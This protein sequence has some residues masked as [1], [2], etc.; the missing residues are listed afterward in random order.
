MNK[1]ERSP[2]GIIYIATNS[3]NGK[4]YVGKTKKTPEERWQV[5][6]DKA[7]M[8]ENI[9]ESNPH[10]K[11]RGT[12]LNNAI[13]KYGNDAFIDDFSF[14][15]NGELGVWN[16]IRSFLHLRSFSVEKTSQEDVVK[17]SVHR[18]RFCDVKYDLNY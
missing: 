15:G 6:L 4:N 13:I 10:T 11:I 5:H 2:H 18:Q 12:H 17:I 8:L 1:E 16:T 9:R 14:V 3:N 7:Q